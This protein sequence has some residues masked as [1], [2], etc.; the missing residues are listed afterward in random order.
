VECANGFTSPVSDQVGKFEFELFESF[1]DTD[2]TW[3]GLVLDVPE[4]IS[5]AEDLADH[6][7]NNSNAALSVITVSEWSGSGQGISLFDPT[8]PTGTY[9]FAVNINDPYRIEIDL[10]GT[11]QGSAIWAQVGKLPP[12]GLDTYTLFESFDDTD[13]TWILQPLDMVAIALV[14]DLATD[15]ETESSPGVSII[16]IS[17]WNPSSQQYET[18]YPDDPGSVFGTRFGYPYRVEVNVSTGLTATWP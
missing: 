13:F 5:D 7:Q 10:T 9:N 6:I 17:F 3:V 15:I 4:D 14:D 1:D 2:F 8:D 16:T 12:I 11:N 18:Y